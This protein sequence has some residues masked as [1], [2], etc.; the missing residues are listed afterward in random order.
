[1]GKT[2]TASDTKSEKPL[3]FLLKT[4]NQMLK[5]GKTAKRH[6]NRKQIRKSK[7]NSIS[8]SWGSTVFACN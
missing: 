1:M 7:I 3:E 4:E 6:Q 8:L 5:S 2:K